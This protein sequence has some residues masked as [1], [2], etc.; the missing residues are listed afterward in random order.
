[1]FFIHFDLTTDRNMFRFILILLTISYSYIDGKSQFDKCIQM[2]IDLPQCI[3]EPF[4]D[5]TRD[6]QEAL[7]KCK[8]DTECKIQYIACVQSKL[9]TCND[10]V[11]KQPI[12]KQ[13][14]EFLQ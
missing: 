3:I 5:Y 6:T 9:S 4:R 10:E 1:M 8:E 14:Q 2:L 7:K 12:I 11:I 13:L